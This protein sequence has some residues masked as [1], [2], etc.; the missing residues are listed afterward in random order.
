MSQKEDDPGFRDRF[1]RFLKER[2]MSPSDFART[3]W[4]TEVEYRKATDSYHEVP[5]GRQLVSKWLSGKAYP[6][7][8]MKP[9]IAKTLGVKT[10]EVFPLID[11]AARPGSGIVF[12]QVNNK[13]AYVELHMELPIDKAM[14][15]MK[16]VREHAA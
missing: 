4:G 3:T 7:D 11:W 15:V 1:A 9:Q 2:N 6:S 5:K 10:S 8:E 13:I 14:E 12:K 16:I